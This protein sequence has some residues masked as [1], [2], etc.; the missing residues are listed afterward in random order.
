VISP[1]ATKV[2]GPSTAAAASAPTTRA[3]K[4]DDLTAQLIDRL[5][6]FRTGGDGK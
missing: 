1:S 2:P 3:A 6:P 5:N 4:S